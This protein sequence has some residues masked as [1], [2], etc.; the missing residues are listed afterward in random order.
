MADRIA[1]DRGYE[2]LP[3]LLQERT[4]G[5]GNKYYV[6]VVGIDPASLNGTNGTVEIGNTSRAALIAGLNPVALAAATI[7]SL[8]AS[9]APIAEQVVADEDGTAFGNHPC[10]S[11]LLQN[12]A[13]A[14]DGATANANKVFVIIGGVVSLEMA[15]GNVPV[16]I[17]CTNSNQITVATKVA[18]QT[19]PVVAVIQA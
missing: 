19:A 7:T 10:R 15:P 13:T 17:E 2:N 1:I 5:S 16:R 11:V 3:R 8:R 4:D 14:D 12:R 18:A 9:V 6:E